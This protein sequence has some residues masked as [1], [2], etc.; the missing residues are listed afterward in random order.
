SPFGGIFRPWCMRLSEL[1]VRASTPRLHSGVRQGKPGKG[2]LAGFRDG[3]GDRLA[4]ISDCSP[5]AS[6][7]HAMGSRVRLCLSLAGL[8]VFNWALAADGTDPSDYRT[9]DKAVAAKIAKSDATVIATRSFLG[10]EVA[11]D[12]Q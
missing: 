12:T 7:V 3:M 11:M 2:I 10:V 9:V 6:G 8:F 1:V 5:S 4:D